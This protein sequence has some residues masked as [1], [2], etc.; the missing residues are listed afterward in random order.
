MPKISVIIPI[1]KVAQYIERC[2]RSLFEQTLDDIEYIFVDDKSPDE[3]VNIL[4]S[5]IKD[6]PRRKN[7]IKLLH[8]KNN[9]GL[10][11]ARNTGL[12][13]ATGEY[14]I[15]CDSDDWIDKDAYEA[16]YRKAK[17]C[18]ADLVLFG[19]YWEYDGYNKPNYPIT[20][21]DKEDA[22]KCSLSGILHNA[23]WNKLIRRSVYTEHGI[24]WEDGVN[25]QE[26]VS[27]MPRLFY[28]AKKVATLGGCYY[29]YFQGNAGS[30]THVWPQANFDNCIR[31]VE[32]LKDFLLKEEVYEEYKRYLA[33]YQCFIKSSMLYYSTI[34]QAKSLFYL[35]PEAKEY[36]NGCP[37]I[38]DGAKKELSSIKKMMKNKRK[39]II[40]KKIEHLILVFK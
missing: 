28:F 25:M 7:Q 33:Y 5:V 35:F 15:H 20:F 23:M 17:E 36:I 21:R 27:V 24:R 11:K 38:D 8:H 6:Y 19:F 39:R 14:V 9:G 29:H 30:Y 16:A 13:A 3:S 32:I 10:A 2:S 31:V 22:F 12:G 4:Q 37:T 1:Y 26:D 18:D 40:K 34:D